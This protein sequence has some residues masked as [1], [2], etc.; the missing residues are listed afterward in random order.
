VNILSTFRN[1]LEDPKLL[2]LIGLSLIVVSTQIYLPIPIL[3]DTPVKEFYE[4]IQNL[5]P[6]SNVYL[7]ADISAGLAGDTV[8]P[9]VVIIATL[10]EADLDIIIYS[11]GA[12]SDP[13]TI[14]MINGAMEVLGH[15]TPYQDSPLYGERLVDLGFVPGGVTTIVSHANSIRDLT[16][17]DRFG[18]NLDDMSASQDFDSAFD[19]DLIIGFGAGPLNAWPGVLTVPYDLPTLYLYHAGG[20]AMVSI[21]YVAGQCEGYVAGVKQ[22]AQLELLSGIDGKNMIGIVALVFVNAFALIGLVLSNFYGIYQRVTGKEV[23]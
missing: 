9:G 21:N 10:L 13:F 11:P 5:P 22:G 14:Q 12:Y 7:A 2:W 1:L 20:L 6:N 15:T 3:I 4:T 19:M 8:E 17:M 23:T 16:P 18:N